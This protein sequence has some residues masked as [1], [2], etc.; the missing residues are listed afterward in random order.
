MGK[1]ETFVM[2]KKKIAVLALCVVVLLGVLLW[3][4]LLDD[5]DTGKTDIAQNDT[6][7]EKYSEKGTMIKTDSDMITEMNFCIS[8][9]EFTFLKT[10]S[11]WKCREYAD[12]PISDAEVLSVSTSLSSVMYIDKIEA[13]DATY[14]DFGITDACDYVWFKSELGDTQIIRGAKAADSSMCYVKINTDS[15]VYLIRSEIADSIFKPFESYRNDSLQKI[16]F[17]N[18]DNIE[19]K[20]VDGEIKLHRDKQDKKNGIYNAWRMTKPIKVNAKDDA[21]SSKIINPISNMKPREYTSDSGD[22][23]SYGF[24]AKDKYVTFT[25]SK[26]KKEAFYFGKTDGTVCYVCID[27]FKNIYAVDADIYDIFDLGAIDICERYLSLNIRQN[28]NNIKIK[29]NN[30]DYTVDFSDENSMKIN[31]KKTDEDSAIREVYE[32]LCGMLADGVYTSSV[33]GEEFYV[34]YDLKNG[35]NIRL[36][37]ASFDERYYSVSKNGEPMFIVLK[38]KV[39]EMTDVIDKYV[40]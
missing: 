37:F 30:M 29:G 1:K 5:K 20:T 19:L 7:S 32:H 26:G 38:S 35:D 33:S 8:G 25:D 2:G 4:Y 39:K 10:D 23:D 14:A 18:I 9:S 15:S 22:F 28:I 13:N 12:I 27:E 31:G 40:K 24:G 17:E 36:S 6:K 11:G 3:V 34:L 16:D 21:V